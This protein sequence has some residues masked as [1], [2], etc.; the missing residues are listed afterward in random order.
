MQKSDNKIWHL[1]DQEEQRQAKTINLIASENVL[2]VEV[3]QVL[4]S[5]LGNKY[6][7]GLPGKRYYAGCQFI[8]QIEQ[9]S[10][11][12]AKKLFG[13]EHTNVQPH[14]G[15]QANMAVYFALLQSGD[16]VL[17]MSFTAGGHLTHGHPATLVGNLYN[18][19]FYGVNKI[20]ELIDLAEVEELA[21]KYKPKLIIAGASAYSRT[22]DFSGFSKIAHKVG[23]YLM[24]DM[25][26]IAGLVAAD[27]HP[28]P[29]PYADVITST[30]HKTLRGPRGAFILCKK[31]LAA[32]IDKA[33]MPGVQGGPFMH[34]IAA[35]AVAFE[36]AAREDFKLYQQQV[37]LNARVMAQE[38]SGSGFR[39]V[40]GGTD[41]HLFLVDLRNKKITGKDAEILLA[42]HDIYVNRNTIPFD[43]QPPLIASGIRIGTP[44]I[45][46]QGATEKEA[47][48]IAQRII[49]ILEQKL[50]L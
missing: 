30:T 10:I 16:T 32:R 2:P 8:D 46:S 26:H 35:K 42:K 5:C 34:A 20:T 39:V 3:G 49:E 13:A 6:A 15:A 25:A 44:F 1:I 37:I 47:R 45:T 33:V 43:Q 36:L 11:D 22:I 24:V 48:A 38:L 23:A 17:S 18:F 41:N 4:A 40:S 50:N 21:L 7:E 29:V 19:V 14:A 27:V 9:L 28:N 12:R 31:E